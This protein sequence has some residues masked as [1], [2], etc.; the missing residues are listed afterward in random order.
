MQ[1]FD[2]AICESRIKKYYATSLPAGRQ[3]HKDTKMH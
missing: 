1:S 2:F 3:G